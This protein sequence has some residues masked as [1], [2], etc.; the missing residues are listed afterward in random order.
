MR[1]EGGKRKAGGLGG[2]RS[3]EEEGKKRNLRKG[4]EVGGKTFIRQ[5]ET[6]ISSRCLS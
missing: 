5:V 2:R 4:Q 3:R 6:I 1:E